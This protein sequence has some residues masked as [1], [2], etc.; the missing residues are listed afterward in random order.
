MTRESILA[1]FPNASES[2][3]QRN[4]GAAGSSHPQPG[5]SPVEEKRQEDRHEEKRPA[6]H[7]PKRRHKG[8][9]KRGNSIFGVAVALRVSDG[10]SDGDNGY[11]T[12]LDCLIAARK[13][14]LEAH[15]KGEF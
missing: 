9:A 5:P 6:I 10:R 15:Q 1:K 14:F 7:P 8:V 12:I 2:F 4:L 13:R 3:I 11:T